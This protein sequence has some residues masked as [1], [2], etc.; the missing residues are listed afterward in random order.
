[1]G[2]IGWDEQFYLCQRW[3]PKHWRI[4][5]LAGFKDTYLE[6][7]KTIALGQADATALD[8]AVG[9]YLIRMSTLTNIKVA[10]EADIPDES[11]DP[12]YRLAVPNDRPILKE[13]LQKAIVSISVEV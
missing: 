11:R 6:N 12:R 8:S 1:M 2:G 4:A 5:D 7:L 10:A 3:Y 13:I 9:N